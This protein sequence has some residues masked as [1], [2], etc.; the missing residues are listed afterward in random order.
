MPD[1]T[2]TLATALTITTTVCTP[3]SQ[4]FARST[5]VHHTSSVP[6][7]KPTTSVD[8]DTQPPPLMQG[9]LTHA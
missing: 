5:T 2:T 1:V 7:V 4:Q 8:N 6:S 3:V 9:L